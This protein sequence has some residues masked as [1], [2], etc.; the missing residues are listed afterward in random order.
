MTPVLATESEKESE[1]TES[2]SESGS[3]SG[4]TTTA[5]VYSGSELPI[6]KVLELAAGSS[7]PTGDF[8]FKIEPATVSSDAEKISGMTVQTGVALTKDTVTINMVDGYTSLTQAE[9]AGLN[10]SVTGVTRTVNYDFDKNATWTGAGIYRY[11]VREDATTKLSFVQEYD[12]TVFT[13]DVYVTN[14]GTT[15][16]P[17]YK[18]SYI[19][20]YDSDKYKSP[21]VFK[22]TTN[23]ESLVISKKVT[24]ALN[25]NSTQEFTFWIKIPVGGDSL[26][27]GSGEGFAAVKTDANGNETKYTAATSPIKVGG[28]DKNED[29]EYL[30]ATKETPSADTGWCSF[31]LKNGESLTIQDVPVGMIYFLYEEQVDGFSTYEENATASHTPSTDK[32]DYT[33][34]KTGKLSKHTIVEKNN[35]ETFWNIREIPNSG[36]VVD[37]LPYI[38]VV[39]AAVAAFAVLLV[40]RKRRN[41]R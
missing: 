24:D 20:A 35:Y 33:Y 37:I 17:D 31:T 25:S 11:T 14:Q 7:V 6:Q 19:K 29:G 12:S 40:S 10:G 21:I 23:T 39:L 8:T 18:T 41:A 30:D 27:L 4:S 36:I 13:V 2:E 5:G 22:N 28:Y 26:T 38:A 15:A 16:A 3:G 34:Y 9:V 32:D 1:T